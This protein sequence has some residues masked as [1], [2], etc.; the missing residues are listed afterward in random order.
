MSNVKHEGKYDAEKNLVITK[1][2]NRPVTF[3]DVDILTSGNERW[4]KSGGLNKVWLIADIS[5]MGMASVKIV[6]DYH[7]KEKPLLEK[8]V[9]NFCTVCSKPL[10]RM[11]AQLFNVLMRE[12]HPTFKTMEEATNWIQQE[13]EKK[14]RF[15]PL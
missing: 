3:E 10:E 13:Q 14:G 2:I 4:Y 6:Q 9:I 1:F 11:A 8:Y 7:N 5:D 15:V 12:K